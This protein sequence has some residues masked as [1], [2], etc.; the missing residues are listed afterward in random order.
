MICLPNVFSIASVLFT[1]PAELRPLG[2]YCLLYCQRKAKESASLLLLIVFFFITTIS[3]NSQLNSIT[4]LSRSSN[5][6]WIGIGVAAICLP[7]RKGDRPAKLI[8]IAR[9]SVWQG[10]HHFGVTGHRALTVNVLIETQGKCIS[11]ITL[12]ELDCRSGLLEH[13]II[14]IIYYLLPLSAC[15]TWGKPLVPWCW[16]EFLNCYSGTAR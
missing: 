4:I 12:K 10:Y 2:V 15:M 16:R 11:R 13:F 3:H 14:I 8:P 9:V 1:V 5:S 6:I 7:G